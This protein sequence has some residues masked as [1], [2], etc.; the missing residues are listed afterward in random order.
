[1][2]KA[3]AAVTASEAVGEPAQGKRPSILHNRMKKNRFQSSGRYLSPSCLPIDGPRDLVADKNEQELQAI[4]E[5]P[6][7]G[8]P[9]LILRARPVNMRIIRAAAT[10]SRT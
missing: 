8:E 2:I 6:F 1:M 5:M 4:P 10:T 3:N 9:D 7:A